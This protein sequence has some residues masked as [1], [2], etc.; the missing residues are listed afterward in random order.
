MAKEKFTR[1][2][3][4][5]LHG[6]Q[7]LQAKFSLLNTWLEKKQISKSL[8]NIT[9]NR[10]I[11]KEMKC[12]KPAFQIPEQPHCK[13]TVESEIQAF[14]EKLRSNLTAYLTD[15][16]KEE[17]KLSAEELTKFATYIDNYPWLSS[18]I[19]QL[20]IVGLRYPDTELNKIAEDYIGKR[21]MGQNTDSVFWLT[22]W[23]DNDFVPLNAV[24]LMITEKDEQFAL[25]NHFNGLLIAK[26]L[27]FIEFQREK[28]LLRLEWAKT[29]PNLKKREEE[30]QRKQNRLDA[31][32]CL[33][34]LAKK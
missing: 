8:Y 13:S 18:K 11:N 14:N 17:V 9:I 22:L 16:K 20:L 7:S 25:S 10:L 32:D 1:P 6:A 27:P 19:N 5:E 29:L 4:A 12:K 2:Q 24:R 31:F 23:S 34:D 3:N 28:E 26:L 21:R 15:R 30:I 33:I